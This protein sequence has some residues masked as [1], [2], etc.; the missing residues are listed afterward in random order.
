[1]GPKG[2]FGLP[3]WK[4]AGVESKEELKGPRFFLGNTPWNPQT[5]VLLGNGNLGKFGFNSRTPKER[6]MPGKV[7]SKWG[8][9][10]CGPKI[11]A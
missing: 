3:A 4:R 10:L 8:N 7:F 1:M 5:Q 6:E 11:W 2:P 9:P